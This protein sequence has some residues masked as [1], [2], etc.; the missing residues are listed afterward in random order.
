MQGGQGGQGGGFNPRGGMG[1]QM[2]FMRNKAQL[3]QTYLLTIITCRPTGVAV[4]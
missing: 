4:L 1:G 2:D 3:N